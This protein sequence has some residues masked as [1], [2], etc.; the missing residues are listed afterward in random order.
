[1]SVFFLPLDVL[2]KYPF[3]KYFTDFMDFIPAIKLMET[4][5]YAPELCKFY[6]SYMF[7]VAIICFLLIA[8]E[9][10]LYMA[11]GFLYPYS[12]KGI[13]KLGG[14]KRSTIKIILLFIMNYIVIFGTLYL[15]FSGSLIGYN[16]REST[17]EHF[18]DSLF[19]MI[20][21]VDLHQVVVLSL[22]V[23]MITI[24]FVGL[25]EVIFYR[26]H[27]CKARRNNG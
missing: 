17:E 8:R 18:V 7:V 9:L 27:L 6:A 19:E 20:L 15:Y 26:R 11:K 1:M 25:P 23:L 14:I 5:T 12:N 16:R 4:K 10:F 22:A 2:S 3:L 13:E 24:G 21:Y